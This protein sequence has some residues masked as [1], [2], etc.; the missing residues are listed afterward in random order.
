MKIRRY[1]REKSL[2]NN[3][4]TNKVC[5]PL[6]VGY[7]CPTAYRSLEIDKIYKTL[8]AFTEFLKSYFTLVV[9]VL[10]LL[11]EYCGVY[12]IVNLNFLLK[13][14]F[15]ISQRI[16]TSLLPWL[17]ASLVVQNKNW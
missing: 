14:N 10:L 3:K 2:L 16:S 6:T 11:I 9:K 4:H 5:C 7:L 1:S 12:L 17:P 8:H 15:V 13:T